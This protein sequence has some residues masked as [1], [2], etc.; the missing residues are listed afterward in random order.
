MAGTFTTF[1]EFMLLLGANVLS[2]AA[3]FIPSVFMTTLNIKMFGIEGGAMLTLLGEIFGA[4]AGFHLYRY[5]FAKAKAGWLNHRFWKFWRHQ[6]DKRIFFGIVAMRLVPFV[7]SGLVTAGAALTT[8]RALPFMVAS[9]IGKIPAVL[10]ELAAVY[11]FIHL[12][13]V[14]LQYAFLAA[15]LVFVAWSWQKSRVKALE[16]NPG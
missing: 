16:K 11:G 4:L 13:P 10:L 9:T 15:V 3:G 5:G 1:L 7:P 12:V 14:S 2:G 8:I 6:P